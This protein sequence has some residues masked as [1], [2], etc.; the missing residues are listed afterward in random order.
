MTDENPMTNE[1]KDGTTLGRPRTNLA[2]TRPEVCRFFVCG[3][4]RSLPRRIPSA[5]TERSMSPF[6][7]S[8][9]ELP[10]IMN[11]AEAVPVDHRDAFL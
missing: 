9:D 2:P 1:V 3:Y 11:L 8:D 7:L 5:Q 4:T 6:S 10:E